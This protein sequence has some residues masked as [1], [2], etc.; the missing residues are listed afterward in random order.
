MMSYPPR[1]KLLLT[2]VRYRLPQEINVLAGFG[3]SPADTAKTI[4]STRTKTLFPLFRRQ[5]AHSAEYYA[6]LRNNLKALSNQK[7]TRLLMVVHNKESKVLL[8][9]DFSLTGIDAHS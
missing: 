7:L 5:G 9:R 3:D 2:G 8:T 1:S 4:S 6:T